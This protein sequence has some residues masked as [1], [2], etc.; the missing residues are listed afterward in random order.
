MGASAPESIS[1]QELLSLADQQG[2]QQWSELSLGYSSSQGDPRLRESIAAS[3]PGLSDSNIITFAGAQEAIFVAY[4]AL[5]QANDRVQVILPIFEP[6]SLVAQG[7]GAK[8]D[9]VILQLTEA[10]GWCLDMNQWVEAIG[11][12]TS[13]S[14][15]NFPH[16]PT[17]RL[18]HHDELGVIVEHCARN[19]CWLFSDE[20]FR[21]L[22]YQRADQLPPVASIY[23]KGISLGVMSKAY[24][25]GG[26]RVGW[27]ACRD[28]RLI[29]RM[30]QIKQYLSICNGRTDEILALI[31]LQHA[32]QLL[33]KNQK[34]NRK[35]IDL[36]KSQASEISTML[37][38]HE[39]DAGC[40][41]FPSLI[42]GQ[43][44][45]EFAKSILDK[46]GV[47]VI[48]GD[49]FIWGEAHF[50]IGFGRSDFPHVLEK[51]MN[52]LR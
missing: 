32:P 43:S 42:D 37:K 11:E 3:Y 14:V 4:H 30:L 35:N 19:N 6:L 13:M 15:I 18:I 2:L 29:E 48:P 38:W 1:L 50:R 8:I 44:A 16:N 22:E 52:Y 31:A 7:I 21:G 27:I 46:T 28:Q 47:M 5:L 40:V 41:A 9:A 25:L 10:G 24:G 26:V 33:K 49:C 34:T 36:L 20:V 51:F 45:R 12:K 23:E 39:P 17:G